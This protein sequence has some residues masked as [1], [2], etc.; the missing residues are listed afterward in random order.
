M[1]ASPPQGQKYDRFLE[2]VVNEAQRLDADYRN[3]IALWEAMDEYLDEINEAPGTFKAFID[4]LRVSTIV[5]THRLFD[6]SSVGIHELIRIAETHNEEIDWQGGNLDATDLQS[7]RDHIEGFQPTLERL[8]KQR[9]KAY[10]HLDKKQVLD[11]EAFAQEFPLNQDDIRQAI[12]LAHDVLQEHHGARYDLHL[13]MRIAA[14]VS[15]R[16]L[17]ELIREGRKFRKE[18]RKRRL[19]S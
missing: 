6:E 9:H 18:K 8:K 14:A 5:L 4:G 15:V 1:S 13:E 10:A 17:L 11:Q 3:F 12:D 16:H 2:R 7:Q 19:N